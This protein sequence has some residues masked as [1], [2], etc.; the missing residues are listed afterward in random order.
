VSAVSE[1]LGTGPVEEG[2][3]SPRAERAESTTPIRARVRASIPLVLV[4]RE[5]N[6]PGSDVLAEPTG[7]RG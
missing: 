7:N 4:C 5:K 1:A 2:T 6:F 3:C